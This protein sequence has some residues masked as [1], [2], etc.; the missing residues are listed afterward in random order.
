MFILTK[1]LQGLQKNSEILQIASKWK[2]RTINVY[3]NPSGPMD[4]RA[5]EV[6]GLKNI[7]GELYLY[8]K[9]VPTLSFDST[10]LLRLIIKNDMIENFANLVG[11]SDTLVV[12]KRV[13]P[14]RQKDEKTFK[15]QALAQNLFKLESA[16]QFHNVLYDVEVLEKLTNAF[17]KKKNVGSL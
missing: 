1:K 9:R 13:F 10:H 5:S 7:T 2:N 12:F 14:E 15:L 11:F 17:M 6:T 3:L 8:G 4:S 16:D